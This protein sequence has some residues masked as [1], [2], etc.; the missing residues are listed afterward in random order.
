MDSMNKINKPDLQRVSRRETVA[1]RMRER[2]LDLG[3]SQAQVGKKLN[4]GQSRIGNWEQNITAVSLD[5]VD[6][7]AKALQCSP[8]YLLGFTDSPLGVVE[9]TPIFEGSAIFMREQ[10]L[11]QR[12][13]KSV[14]LKEVTVPDD[15]MQPELAK[16]SIA[17]VDT[18]KRVI[19]RDGIYAYMDAKQRISFRYFTLN[20]LGDGV[21]VRTLSTDD[22]QEL[23]GDQF[24][25]LQKKIVG[26]YIGGWRWA[27]E[28]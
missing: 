19:D 15:L 5:S 22:K 21:L 17:V 3:L 16:G 10:D 11:K 7:I 2:R 8:E 23:K 20:V 9:Q 25:E 28:N 12:G 26:L 13:I 1:K 18:S 14:D 24:S 6:T 27:E 4:G